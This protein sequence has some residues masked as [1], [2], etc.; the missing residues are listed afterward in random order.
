MNGVRNINEGRVIGRQSCSD[1]IRSLAWRAKIVNRTQLTLRNSSGRAQPGSP[2]CFFTTSIY[3][4]SALEWFSGCQAIQ[5]SALAAA[6][7][8]R[9]TTPG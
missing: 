8:G 4:T 3:L 2:A 5:Y 7:N 6:A 9:N 1:E